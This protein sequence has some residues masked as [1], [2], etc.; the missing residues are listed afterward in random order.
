MQVMAAVVVALPLLVE[1][2]RRLLWLVVMAATVQ[3]RLFL[4]AA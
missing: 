1:I 3:H 2:A 4:E